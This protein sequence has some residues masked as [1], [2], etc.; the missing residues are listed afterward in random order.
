MN[1]ILGCDID[2]QTVS[3]SEIKTYNSTK[4]PNVSPDSTVLIL[5]DQVQNPF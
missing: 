5:C 2:F 1:D 4:A 3:A